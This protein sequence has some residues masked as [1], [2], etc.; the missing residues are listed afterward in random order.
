MKFGIDRFGAEGLTPYHGFC[1]LR[2]AGMSEEE[3]FKHTIR[4]ILWSEHANLE[5]FLAVD[6]SVVR[7]HLQ[8]RMDAVNAALGNA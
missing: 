4:A 2:S 6:P 5:T 3:A 7:L 1:E 8:K